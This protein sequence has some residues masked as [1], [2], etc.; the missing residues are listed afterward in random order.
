MDKNVTVINWISWR[1]VLSHTTI[2]IQFFPGNILTHNVTSIQFF[3]RNWTT[4]WHQYNLKPEI[5][6][7]CNINT[8][9]S[10]N[11]AHNVIPIQFL[12]EL[13]QQCRLKLM[14]KPT[15]ANY[16]RIIIKICLG[17]LM[18]NQ[19]KTPHSF[20]VLVPQPTPLPPH[21]RKKTEFEFCNLF[22]V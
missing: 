5:D 12:R 1:W 3:A 7:Q 19:N 9:L 20:L 17:R 14:P 2:T 18:C 21:V 16:D 6:P 4:S 11:L 10:Q 13:A 22:W 15:L 8:I